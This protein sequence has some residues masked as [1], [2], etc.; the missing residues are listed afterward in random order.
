MAT[1]RDYFE[2]DFSHTLIMSSSLEFHIEDLGNIL[3]ETQI[4]L[5]FFSK[6]LF[7]SFLVQNGTLSN[8]QLIYLIE[9]INTIWGKKLRL[10]ALR[11]IKLPKPFPGQITLEN[12][13]FMITSSFFGGPPTR[14]DQLMFTGRIYI[15]LDKD[16]TTQEQVE[17]KSSL[18]KTGPDPQF[19]LDPQFRGPLYME[20]CEKIQ[21]R[22]AFISHDSRDKQN[23]AR[24]IAM[25]LSRNQIPVWYDEFSLPVG[26]KL[27]ESIEAGIKECR[28]CI[29]I[30]TK[31]FISNDS[32]T[33]VEFDSVFTKEI[34]EKGNILLPVWCGVT[35]R[36]VYD[37]SPWL[38]N[39]KAVNWVDGEE[40]VVRKLRSEILK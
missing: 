31:H 18:K 20:N 14:Y 32:W 11:R 38:A 12:S 19:R 7:A 34:F 10:P 33:K 39:I 17:I 9:E 5:D 3:V 35:A 22:L 15:Y 24:P 27:R 23:I 37:Y 40:E 36:E 4:H 6:T 26:A 21:I 16:L 13:P 30:V 8:T 28:K 2:T 1:I 25:S 29:L